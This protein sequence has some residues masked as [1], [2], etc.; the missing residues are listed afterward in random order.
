[1][2]LR[3]PAWILPFAT[4]LAALSGCESYPQVNRSDSGESPADL[5]D[6]GADMRSDV[7]LEWDASRADSSGEADALRFGECGAGIVQS[8]YG[9]LQPA[10]GEECDDGNNVSGDGC[11]AYCSVEYIP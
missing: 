10:R 9:I 11:S 6:A 7:V 4:L 3:L 8:S 2:S 1:M 5:P